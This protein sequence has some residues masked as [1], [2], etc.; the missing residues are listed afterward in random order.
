MSETTSSY[1]SGPVKIMTSTTGDGGSLLNDNFKTLYDL[2]V[3]TNSTEGMLVNVP[4]VYDGSSNYSVKTFALPSTTNLTSSTNYVAVYNG[5][6]V[7][8][9]QYSSGTAQGSA[10]D[11]S[12]L[13]HPSNGSA[14]DAYYDTASRLWSSTM[15]S[16]G[17]FRK[18]YKE[19]S[20]ASSIVI[21]LPA[22]GSWLVTGTLLFIKDT[23]NAT[24]PATDPAT[25]NLLRVNI[26]GLN[27]VKLNTI[28]EVWDGTTW[29]E[30]SSLISGSINTSNKKLTISGSGTKVTILADLTLVGGCRAYAG[31]SLS[32]TS[33]S[34][35]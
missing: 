5:G 24:H 35:G 13:T 14:P 7:G 3:P 21:D 19:A 12:E 17:P 8:W 30:D 32:F 22:F 16:M 2:A 9:Q 1:R 18:T 20:K 10:S 15:S 11:V 6:T 25:S 34:L 27:T 4:T 26:Y 33:A 29:S 31:S 28:C 23:T